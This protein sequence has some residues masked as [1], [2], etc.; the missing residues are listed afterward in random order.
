MF[1][2]AQRIDARVPWS[3]VFGNA[4]PVE[5]EIGPGRGD[6][7]FAAA[8]RA[9]ERNFFAVERTVG[10][11][12]WL[13]REAERRG[14]AN[15]RAVAADARCVVARCVPDDSVAAYHVYFPDPWPKR[16]HHRRRL[17]DGHFAAELRRT[18]APGGVVHLATDVAPLFASYAAALAAGGLARLVDAA[19]PDRPRTHFER[20]YAAAGTHYACFVRR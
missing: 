2:E 12:G 18:L 15:V 1:L 8:A 13:L 19:P 7:L 17:V 5:V 20:R 10:V 14:L 16:R 6:T 11:V 3:A 9:P 4:R